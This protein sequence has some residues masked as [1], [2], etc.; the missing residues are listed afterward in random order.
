[1]IQP[2]PA[3][4]RRRPYAITAEGSTALQ[5]HLTVLARIARTGHQ[6]LATA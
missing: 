6:R 1:M 4:R 2:L 5:E 3:E